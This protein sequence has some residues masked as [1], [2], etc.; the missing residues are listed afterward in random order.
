MHLFVKA[1]QFLALFGGRGNRKVS[2]QPLR[3]CCCFQRNIQKH[4]LL[5]PTSKGAWH[6][7]GK[8]QEKQQSSKGLGPDSDG[9]GPR[10]T[11]PA[12][13]TEDGQQE[14]ISWREISEWQ[15]HMDCGQRSGSQATARSH[16][17]PGS[18]NLSQ[19]KPQSY[20]NK[21]KPQSQDTN[22][23]PENKSHQHANIL[24]SEKEAEFIKYIICILYIGKLVKN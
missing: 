21:E 17:S 16:P 22:Y 11:G 6:G 24:W 3:R 8:A 18:V 15:G 13:H 7:P 1:T 14:K 20:S 10:V 2:G 4:L 5:S 19:A 23:I 12:K 9:T